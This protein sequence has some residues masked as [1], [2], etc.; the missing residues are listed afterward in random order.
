MKKATANWN[1]KY[2]NLGK[3]KD[4]NEEQT[5]EILQH[6]AENGVKAFIVGT[7]CKSYSKAIVEEHRDDYIRSIDKV[8]K[9]IINCFERVLFITWVCCQQ[10]TPKITLYSDF[11]K[12]SVA[13][14]RGTN[15]C[16]PF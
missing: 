9:G 7:N 5:Q 3:S 10:C 15:L 14:I 16:S 1:E 8:T 12:S 4:L 13:P 11:N 6:L 2:G